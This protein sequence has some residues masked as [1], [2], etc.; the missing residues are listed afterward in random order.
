MLRRLSISGLKGRPRQTMILLSTIILSFFFVTIAMNLLST[1]QINRV[2]QR[3][4]AFGEWS[5]VFVA[6]QPDMADQLSQYSLTYS[7]NRILGRD[8]RF[9]LIATADESFWDMS[10][11]T[12]LEGSLPQELDEIVLT[13][14]QIS[15][16]P[17]KPTI[18]QTVLVTFA[19]ARSDHEAYSFDPE[20]VSLIDQDLTA[21][22]MYIAEN[23]DTYRDRIL[24]DQAQWQANRSEMIDRHLQ[25]F[26]GYSS[27]FDRE[28]EIERFVDLQNGRY[29]RKLALFDT[30][31][32]SLDERLSLISRFLE[33]EQNYLIE[34][35]IRDPLFVSRFSEGDSEEGLRQTAQLQLSFDNLIDRYLQA[36]T[37]RY[38]SE[39][40]AHDGTIFST[41]N[42]YRVARYHQLDM[43]S[44]LYQHL[45]EEVIPGMT[46]EREFPLTSEL[47][48]HR[49]MTVSGII[50]NYHQ[51]WD[52]PYTQYATGFV[53]PETGRQL[54]EGGVSYSKLEANRSYQPPVH[55]FVHG[56]DPTA[57]ERLFP[58]AS[59]LFANN[60]GSGQETGLDEDVL[61]LILLAV[62][63]LVTAFSIFQISLIQFK[64]RLRKLALLRAVGA[65]FK[66]LRHILAWESVY[67]I[68]L[69]LPIGGLLGFVISYVL[70]WLN[71]RLTGD[72][73]VMRINPDWLLWGYGLTLL[74]ILI[75]LFVP[76]L[77]IGMVP[78][79]GNVAVVNKSVMK[80]T[81]ELLGDLTIHRQSLTSI[82]RR[83][84]RFTRKQQWIQLTL[85]S[86]IILILIGSYLLIYLAF[87]DYREKTVH[88]NMPDFEL[89]APFQQGLRVS[90]AFMEELESIPGV[91][92]TELFVRGLKAF[93]WYDG[94]N[95]GKLDRTF[96]QLIPDALHTEH[97]GT[98]EDF[99][100]PE[101]E[102]YLIKD[103]SVIDIY[104]IVADSQ[105][106][107]AMVRMLP[108]DFDL[109][110]FRTEQQAI[111]LMPS[112][113]L[114]RSVGLETIDPARLETISREER[115]KQ[116]LEL[117]GA[118]HITYDI[119]RA[120]VM[121]HDQ[122]T[123]QIDQVDLAIPLGATAGE[124]KRKLNYI[125]QYR[126][127]ITSVIY[128]LPEEGFW[129]LSD[130]VQNPIL[131]FSQ[132]SMDS[133]YPYRMHSVLD[134]NIIYRY[135]GEEPA[136]R[137]GSSIIQVD[138]SDITEQGVTEL[139]RLGF[140]NGYQ[141]NSLYL[142]KQQLYT[143]GIRTGLIIGLLSA[144]LLLIAV[145]I[146]TGSF[147]GQLEV[148]RERIGILQSLGVTEKDFRRAYL[149]DALARVIEAIILA[150]AIII[151]GL[152][153]YLVTSGQSGDLITELRITLSDYKWL[154]HLGL[155]LLFGFM[156]TLATYLP[157]GRILRRRPVENIRSLQ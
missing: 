146:Q 83:H 128:H 114:D 89:E 40:E 113:Q 152:I 41:R 121:K 119:R 2:I 28:A 139:K 64:K 135:L 107:Q 110:S 46:L 24:R 105:L 39:L 90:R 84:R 55:Y 76:M 59:H 129:P 31:T 156:G 112:Y 57:V 153:V 68:S 52:G 155:I 42:S 66:Q 132:Y 140:K 98:V 34:E 95:Q 91:A 29:A 3:R 102:E 30:T 127:P 115:M 49:K 6:D 21:A 94:V 48:L 9:G 13:E 23:W 74:S 87:G 157:I 51:V 145:Q 78:L 7:Q 154:W 79:R 147:R 150:H 100:L 10:N 144:T 70:I 43:M 15:Y 149:K 97:Y 69:G 82:N 99:H 92:G 134:F 130:T 120:A 35:M 133:L 77:R 8:S 72:Q 38:S 54:F 5:N 137:F 96:R 138:Q 65:T 131:F 18:G 148:E 118:G 56:T 73:L 60:L 71:N 142:Q 111:L 124:S 125:R 93:M 104:G 143:K 62:I 86:A 11:I 58:N 81:R 32:E 109:Q 101:G 122:S 16:F 37:A 141:V 25:Q 80:S 4:E 126:I 12:L 136:V 27:T 17:E 1:S 53:S 88:S 19:V 123:E 26:V 20:T 45:P 116:V 117:S 22:N 47:V 63:T 44:H 61:S 103:A 67:L 75:G 50:D 85:M 33:T 108:A 14:S 151:I 106:E 36:A